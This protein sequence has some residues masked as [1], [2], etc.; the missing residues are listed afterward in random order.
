VTELSGTEKTLILDK[1]KFEVSC[2]GTFIRLGREYPTI[3]VGMIPPYAILHHPYNAAF[4]VTKSLKT[5][6]D[7]VSKS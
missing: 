1:S 3:K 5:T 7:L 4:S 6:T 2:L